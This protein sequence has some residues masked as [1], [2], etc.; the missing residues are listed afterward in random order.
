MREEVMLLA[1]L[2]QGLFHTEIDF[3]YG[4][5]ETLL[6]IIIGRRSD[7]EDDII[8]TQHGTCW[9]PA[10]QAC[11]GTGYGADVDKYFADALNLRDQFNVASALSSAGITPGGSY[12]LDKLK[13]A[14]SAKWPGVKATFICSGAYL[15]EIRIGVWATSMG[16]VVGP[17]TSGSNSCH[18]NVTYA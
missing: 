12:T 4:G 15:V 17:P 16:G 6:K 1:T 9:S 2:I 5:S 18:S 10:S 8:E 13:D 7:V 3:R 14:I 11:V